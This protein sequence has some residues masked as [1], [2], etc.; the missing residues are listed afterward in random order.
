M[1]MFSD[2]RLF[3]SLSTCSHERIFS[4]IE[5]RKMFPEQ[6]FESLT[7]VA[8]SFAEAGEPVLTASFDPRTISFANCG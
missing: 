6:A 1:M 8:E 3:R 4:E 7:K 2:A 5:H